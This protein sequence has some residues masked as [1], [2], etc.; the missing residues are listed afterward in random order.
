MKIPHPSLMDTNT[1]RFWSPGYCKW[2]EYKLRA[3]L[4]LPDTFDIHAAYEEETQCHST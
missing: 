3:T 1:P 2:L 4:R